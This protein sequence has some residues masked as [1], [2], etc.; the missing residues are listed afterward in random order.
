M[1]NVLQRTNALEKYRGIDKIACCKCSHSMW[2]QIN[3]GIRCHCT[4]LAAI[5][6][7]SCSKPGFDH[8]TGNVVDC[9][10]INRNEDEPNLE[11]QIAVVEAIPNT[12][13]GLPVPTPIERSGL[14]KRHSWASAN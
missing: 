11:E 8:T 7:Q 6:F 4:V 9:D 5:V 12:V 1:S 14:L 2:H 3:D 13:D 10:S